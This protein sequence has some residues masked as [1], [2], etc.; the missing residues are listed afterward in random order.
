MSDIMQRFNV[1]VPGRLEEVAR[2]CENVAKRFALRFASGEAP[3]GDWFMDSVQTVQRTRNALV[4]VVLWFNHGSSRCFTEL[5]RENAL[6]R[7][8]TA[9]PAEFRLM[10]PTFQGFTSCEFLDN[11]PD[12]RGPE[13][14]YAA[15]EQQALAAETSLTAAEQAL[16]TLEQQAFDLGV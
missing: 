16:W 7:L 4:E 15:L 11:P 3:S 2:R 12:N 9:L 6:E 8:G 13:R 10:I 5:S 14:D 1:E